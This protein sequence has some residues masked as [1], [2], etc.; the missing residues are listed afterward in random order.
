MGCLDWPSEQAEIT[1]ILTDHFGAPKTTKFEFLS[2]R[3]E[4]S[5]KHASKS[6]NSYV[7]LWGMHG[8]IWGNGVKTKYREPEV[9]Q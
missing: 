7:I 6:T 4:I 9:K 8:V 5:E 1:T 2:S 3:C